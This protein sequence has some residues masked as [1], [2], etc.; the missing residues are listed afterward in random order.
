MRSRG[1][2]CAAAVLLTVMG[3][4]A[5]AQTGTGTGTEPNL[6]PGTFWTDDCSDDRGLVRNGRVIGSPG[7]PNGARS[8]S[9]L[10]FSKITYPNAADQTRWPS[11][12]AA[13]SRT[14]GEGILYRIDN[15]EIRSLSNCHDAIA[16]QFG[17]F[18]GFNTQPT[19]TGLFPASTCLTG[20]LTAVVTAARSVYTDQL[21][22][23]GADTWANNFE[24]VCGESG[25]DGKSG[26][27]VSVVGYSF[28]DDTDGTVAPTLHLAPIIAIIDTTNSTGGSGGG[29]GGGGGGG[30]PT[31]SGNLTVV[32]PDD[33]L[34]APVVMANASST[35]VL[36]ST[37]ASSVSTNDVAVSAA[38]D[39]NDLIV[40]VN[41]PVIPAPGIGDEILTIQTTPTTGAGTH[42]ITITAT[43]GTN[44]ASASVFVEVLCDPPFI[45]GLDQPKNSTVSPGRPA[46]LSVTASGSGPFTYQ[47]FTG[48][49]GLVNFPLAGGTT[50]NF[51]T[52]ALNDTA[53]YWVR[54]TNP[55]G[56]V[57]SQ[58]VTVNVSSGAKPTSRR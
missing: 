52:S 15:L 5:F 35:T 55:C 51:T 41:Q 49:S 21:S 14:T 32:L 12:I 16:V 2:V 46:L 43:D 26:Q 37:F 18:G 7:D 22:V 48:A 56:S 58:T 23:W 9:L 8:I 28:W 33:V 42:V 13:T 57:N 34:A 4:P 38:S 17:N 3:G 25:G 11:K 45:L 20:A 19:F 36:F 31:P 1:V 6:A 27:R 29:G 54:V 44:T 24:K 40:S 39:A 47:W 30:T 50:A 53:S 10:A